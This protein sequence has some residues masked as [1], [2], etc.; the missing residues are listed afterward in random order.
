MKKKS[1]SN[2]MAPDRERHMKSILRQFKREFADKYRRGDKEHGGK[3]E[4]GRDCLT[5][6]AQEAIDLVAY[7]TCERVKREKVMRILEKWSG[8]ERSSAMTVFKLRK[9]Y[10]FNDPF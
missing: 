1:K 10:G 6:A 3:L 9:L 7:L 4:V 8:T 5:E 2:L